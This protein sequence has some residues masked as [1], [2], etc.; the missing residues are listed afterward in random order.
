MSEHKVYV[1]IELDGTSHKVGQLWAYAS[2]KKESASFQYD[3]TWL[4]NP[5]KFALEPALVLMQ[6]LYHTKTGSTLFGAI[7]D[8]APDRWGRILMRK[9]VAQ[10]AR[11]LRKNPPTLS[12][13]DYLLGVYD[14]SRQGALRF[15]WEEKGPFLQ[16]ADASPIPPLLKLSRLLS[17]TEKLIEDRESAEDLKLLLAPG[18]SLG[19]ARPKASV[20]EKEGNLA[21]AKFPCKGDE[22]NTVLWEALALTL[23]SQAG[24]DVPPFHLEF[25]KNKPVLVVRRFDRILT[26]RI[27]FLSA[28]SMV[29]AKDNEQ[30]SYLE[31]VDALKQY[32]ASPL[33]DM[34]ELW[35]RI[36]FSILISNTDDHLRNHGFL[37][38]RYKGWKLSP[39]YDVNPTSVEVKPRILT[40][41]IDLV[42][43]TASLDLALSV[44][45]EFGIKL[46]DAKLMAKKIGRVVALWKKMAL[47]MKINPSEIERMASAFDHEDLALSLSF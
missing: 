29:G 44:A 36:V 6:G 7:G 10:K 39:L 16:H 2:H 32:G 1:S 18:S 14:E 27:P 5:E 22:Y 23:A 8:S 33:Q 4:S 41:T 47:Q 20:Y 34:C 43:G 24:L 37:Y 9:A 40:T 30:H 11:G 26:H 46:E 13:I 38:E 19:G 42:D 28:M 31:L 15:S 17:A 12:E 3:S 45:K 35:K 25:I 21:I